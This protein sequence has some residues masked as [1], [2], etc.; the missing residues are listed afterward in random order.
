MLAGDTYFDIELDLVDHRMVVSTNRAHEPAV[1][2]L[3]QGLS[4]ANFYAA[5]FH[6]L[7]GFGIDVNIVA[8]PYGVP[9]T[10]P[11]AHDHEHRAYDRV[12]VR[13]WWE[14]IMWTSDVLAEFAST[15]YGKQSVPQL[16]W[17]SF[18]LAMARFS[19]HRAAGP[20]KA[21][22]VEAD[23][24]SHEVIAFG[25]W[26]GDANVPAPT[27]YTYTAP[28]PSNLTTF[29]LAPSDAGWQPS[30]AGHLGLLSYDAVRASADP[31]ATLLAFFQSGYDAGTAATGWKMEGI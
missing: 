9:I 5:L 17:H 18:D 7:H 13:R 1:V 31:R 14:I 29:A 3:R 6:A 11:F 26:A 8:K 2:E 15:F 27:F 19:G 23:A 10:T 16:F 21:D 20:P 24:Y 4:V 28:E 22:P 12:M 30:G 25:F